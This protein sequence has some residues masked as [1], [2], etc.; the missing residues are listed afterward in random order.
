MLADTYSD[1]ECQYFIIPSKMNVA[2]GDSE[3]DYGFEEP[4]AP[5]LT[6]PGFVKMQALGLILEAD[7]G[8]GSGNMVC[9]LFC[10]VCCVG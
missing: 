7:P 1:L 9:A 8:P 5:G 4:D 3:F 2:G 10:I 6:K